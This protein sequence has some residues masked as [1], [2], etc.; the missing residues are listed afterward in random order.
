VTE[1]PASQES[2]P[3]PPKFVLA[4]AEVQDLI[5]K[6]QAMILRSAKRSRRP[7]EKT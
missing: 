4:E 7:A 6:I 5:K 2:A 3:E 1:N